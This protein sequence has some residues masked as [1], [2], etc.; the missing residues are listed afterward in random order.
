MSI[1]S[2]NQTINW[3]P[4]IHHEITPTSDPSTVKLPSGFVVLIL[5][6]SRGIGRAT[7]VA[8]AKA[9]A[10]S[11]I[12]TGRDQTTLRVAEQE[13]Q[14]AAKVKEADVTTVVCD[15]C[16]DENLKALA[17]GVHKKYGKLDAL[18]INAGVANDLVKTASGSMDWPKDI[19]S[20]D[21]VD[22]DHVF[23]VNFF[24]GV[25]A[26][27]YLLP[28]LE[29]ASPTS[30]K[31][32]VWVTSS[33]IHHVDPKL[34]AMGYSLSKYTAARFV[35]YVHHAHYAKGVTAFGIQPGSVM[36]DMGKNDLPEGKGWEKSKEL[37]CTIHALANFSAVLIDDV[38][39]GG[40]LCV[41]LSKERREW[42][43]GRWIDA[44]WDLEELGR[45]RERIVAEDL[46]KFRMA[47]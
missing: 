9:G 5:G 46:L 29:A 35:E 13:V 22:F 41:W 2:R 25:A 30:P 10:S 3:C 34:M 7:A 8:Y 6:A 39:L 36:T 11:I 47:M 38:N 16:K 44:R 31:A 42:L 27:H 1:A 18:I 40:G 28:S 37:S 43:S 32:V 45:R 15:V 26:L 4:P 23:S 14:I 17:E 24:A 12:I 19:P 21:L 33:S 20:L